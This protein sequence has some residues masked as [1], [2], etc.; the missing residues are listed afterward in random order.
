[1]KDKIELNAIVDAIGGYGDE[2]TKMTFGT[3]E[4][5]VEVLVKKK[6]SL[7]ERKRFTDAI[8]SMCFV[9]DGDGNI[10]YCP[11]L[12]KFAFEY[13]A[14]LFFTN[15]ELTGDVEEVCEFLAGTDVVRRIAMVIDEGYVAELFGEVNELIEYHK[16]SLLKK[17]KLDDVLGGISD[18]AKALGSKFDGEDGESLMKYLEENVP[19]FK[20][21]MA[22]VFQGQQE[23]PMIN[24]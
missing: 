4:N 12:K 10:M 2:Y 18:V 8:V 21:E 11:Y 19:N 14:V 13:H 24:K 7:V 22:K 23:I 5:T 6:L 9:D 1:M 15:I 3:K 16:E 20:E 17:S